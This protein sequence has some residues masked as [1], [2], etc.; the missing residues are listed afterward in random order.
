MAAIA[1][2]G[3]ERSQLLRAIGAPYQQTLL[4]ATGLGDFDAPFLE[5]ARRL[6]VEE[7]AVYQA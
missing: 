7:G 5:L 3:E 2:G 6:R 1:N 4:T